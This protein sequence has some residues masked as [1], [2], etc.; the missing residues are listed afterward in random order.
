[1]TRGFIRRLRVSAAPVT[2]QKSGT[3]VSITKPCLKT[4]PRS[5]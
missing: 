1:M 5:Q 3:I 4:A 2:L